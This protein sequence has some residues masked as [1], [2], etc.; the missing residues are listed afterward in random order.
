MTRSWRGASA[1]AVV[2]TV[3]AVLMGVAGVFAVEAAPANLL[4][5]LS[6]TITYIRRDGNVWLFG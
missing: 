2:V 5:D 1:A 6:G 4:A 3:L